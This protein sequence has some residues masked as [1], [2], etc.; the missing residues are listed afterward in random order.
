ML[1]RD[2]EDDAAP[3]APP[4]RRERS[5]PPPPEE[6]SEIGPG[7]SP[8][9]MDDEDEDEED[10]EDEGEDDE[11]SVEPLSIDP[12]SV[13]EESEEREP[14][15]DWDAGRED[16]E[17]EERESGRNDG[18]PSMI[19]E[20]PDP[21]PDAFRAEAAAPPSRGGMIGFAVLAVAVL[22]IIAG[23]IFAREQIVAAWPPAA[24][25]YNM[26][27]L[28]IRSIA[29]GLELR[30]I[31]SERQVGEGGELLVV[32]GIVFNVSGEE[33]QVPNMKLVLFDRE[34]RPVQ[35]LVFA[36]RR[37]SMLPNENMNF[38]VELPGPDRDAARLE[39]T[40]TEDA[41]GEPMSTGGETA[42]QSGEMR[43]SGSTAAST[44]EAMPAPAS[45]ATA[46]PAAAPAPA[47]RQMA[48]LNAPP[49]TP[50]N[51]LE[52]P[53]ENAFPRFAGVWGTE[54]ENPAVRLSATEV[55]VLVDGEPSKLIK[56]RAISA[57]MTNG[58]FVL[59]QFQ[60]GG[61]IKYRV[62]A[63]DRLES[64]EVGLPNGE[65]VMHANPAMM[66]CEEERRK[67]GSA[68]A[69]AAASRPRTERS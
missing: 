31:N 12:D 14:P 45:E 6:F 7:P 41:V 46:A 47:E 18:I 38:R 59:F 32:R 34:D 39:V 54:C 68:P 3:A 57:A 35:T 8:V 53:T 36:P 64:V 15:A 58:E 28:S 51:E 5:A 4:P 40:F 11:E 67:P 10:L 23:G 27:S 20:E 1:I 63:G 43:Q 66:R 19:G 22:A 30:N 37:E 29:A 69:G 33:K 17:D 65:R 24:K 55:A 44:A 26:M 16:E 48:A 21:I 56:P 25:L 62:V 50:P 13:G 42:P 61:Y 9:P 2:E 49:T 60:G 52:G